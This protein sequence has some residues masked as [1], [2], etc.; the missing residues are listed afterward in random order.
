MPVIRITAGRFTLVTAD[1]KR[2]T[3]AG[4]ELTTAGL[5]AIPTSR[6]VTSGVMRAERCGIP[7]P[8]ASL[9]GRG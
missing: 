6:I 4:T 2:Q 3:A 1:V 7:V 8:A 5:F 9:A